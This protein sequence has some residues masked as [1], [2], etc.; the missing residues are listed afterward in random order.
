MQMII[1]MDDRAIWDLVE[2]ALE[3]PEAS[4]LYLQGLATEIGLR[5][6]LATALLSV[7]NDMLKIAIEVAELLRKLDRAE[8]LLTLAKL[9]RTGLCRELTREYGADYGLAW[10][11][12]YY[13]KERWA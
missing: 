9:G 2:T 6:S 11:A 1:E 8:T 13:I 4:K 5:Q 10:K 3:K 7:Q 12:A